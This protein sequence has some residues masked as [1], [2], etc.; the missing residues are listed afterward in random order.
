MVG[1][2]RFILDLIWIYCL[3]VLSWVGLVILLVIHKFL[4]GG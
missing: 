1:L 4:V 3:A 2:M